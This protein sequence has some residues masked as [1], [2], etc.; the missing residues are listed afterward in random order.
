MR[1]LVW[2]L[3]LSFLLALACGPVML[4]ILRSL[5]LGQN[6]RD[7]GPQ[8]HLSKG[9]TPT[10]GGFIFLVPCI[11]VTLILFTG[12]IQ[13]VLFAVAITLGFTIIGFL[14][15]IIKAYLHRSLGLKPYQKIIGQIGLAL[16]ASLFAAYNPNIGTKLFIPYLGYIQFGWFYVPFTVFVIVGMVNSVNLTDGLD[17]LAGGM[18]VV[19]F[20]GFAMVAFYLSFIAGDTGNIQQ[21]VSLKNMAIFGTAMAG[22][23]L[24][25]LR[26][27]AHPAHVFMGDTGALGLGAAISVLAITTRMLYLLPIM[28]GMFVISSVTSIIQTLS[29]KTRQKRVFLMAPLH[30]H[31]EL[32]GMHETKVVSMYYVIT[33]I[34]V[35]FGII[36]LMM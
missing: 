32:S 21:S 25:F 24:G 2:P 36:T 27:N 30:H 11:A 29:Y 1:Q 4:P 16:L 17:G 33:L 28:G 20:A 26:L 5:K 31:F 10:M 15:D 8:A 23:C 12:S 6:V 35:I 13:W 3:V 9:G 19:V 22:G 7:D 18:S 14:D 34:L